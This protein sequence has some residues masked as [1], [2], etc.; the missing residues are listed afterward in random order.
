MDMVSYELLPSTYLLSLNLLEYDSFNFAN[1][2]G[3]LQRLQ[4]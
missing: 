3:V 1:A 2:E 4:Y